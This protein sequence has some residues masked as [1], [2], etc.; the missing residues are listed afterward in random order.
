MIRGRH[1]NIHWIQEQYLQPSYVWSGK[2]TADEFM[3][4]RKDGPNCGQVTI[5]E[6]LTISAGSS[7]SFPLMNWTWL[8]WGCSSYSCATA[9]S[10]AFFA[11]SFKLANKSRVNSN[12]WRNNFQKL[13][14]RPELC[15]ETWVRVSQW[16]PPEYLRRVSAPKRMHFGCRIFGPILPY[17][18]LRLW[19]SPIPYL[20]AVQIVW[21]CQNGIKL[22]VWLTCLFIL[23]IQ[24]I[25]PTFNELQEGG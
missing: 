6:S 11:I 10:S 21:F 2:W 7:Q 9:S 14:Q 13:L 18:W 25:P 22:I 15:V 5:E 8:D 24:K 19:G 3:L 17:R 23:F 4:T 1:S 12:Q 16:L 20:T